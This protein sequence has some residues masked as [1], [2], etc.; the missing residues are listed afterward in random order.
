M[1]P[2][3]SKFLGVANENQESNV[4]G[5]LYVGILGLAIDSANQGEYKSAGVRPIISNPVNYSFTNN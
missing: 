3:A 4:D 5:I 1:C 2:T